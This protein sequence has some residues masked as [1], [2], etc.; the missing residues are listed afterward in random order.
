ME[1][2]PPLMGRARAL[3]LEVPRLAKGGRGRQA[4][5]VDGWRALTLPVAFTKAIGP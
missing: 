2:E 3:R 4:A 5:L 1:V